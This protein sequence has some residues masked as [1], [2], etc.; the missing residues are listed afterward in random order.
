MPYCA[1][2]GTESLHHANMSVMNTLSTPLLYSENGVYRCI[3]FFL[4]LFQN[5]DC[6]YSLEPPRQEQGKISTFFNRNFQFLITNIFQQ[7]FSIF[8]NLG[9]IC[10]LHGHVFVIMKMDLQHGQKFPWEIAYRNPF[11]IQ[12]T[13]SQTYDKMQYP[14]DSILNEFALQKHQQSNISI[15]LEK[16]P[17]SFSHQDNMSV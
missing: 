5:I 13:S 1:I 17:L 10:I 6:G 14:T 16:Q 4:F 9:K 11:K 3:H 15:F 8:Y 7:K 12:N 2:L